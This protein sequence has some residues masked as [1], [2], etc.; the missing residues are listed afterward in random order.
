MKWSFFLNSGVLF[1]GL[2]MFACSES[3]SSADSLKD[4]FD[5]LSYANSENQSSSSFSGLSPDSVVAGE[6]K[7]TRDNRTYKT[8]KIGNQTWMAENLNYAQDTLNESWCYDNNPTNCQKKGRMYS[9]MGAINR[10]AEECGYQKACSLTYPVQGICPEGWHI[11]SKEE[12]EELI[13]TVGGYA[14]AGAR[15]KSKENWDPAWNGCVGTDDYQFSAVSGGWYRPYSEHFGEGNYYASIWSSTELEDKYR[16][17]EEDR[18]IM[19]YTFRFFNDKDSVYI[20]T[21]NRDYGLSV[22]C[23]KDDSKK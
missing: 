4:Y 12:F 1:V 15:L 9:W 6:F 19:V 5:N 13:E 14:I 18:H 2:F 8:V 21:S 3:E 16:D 7:D 17:K 11:P 20:G 10:T 22:R 23:L